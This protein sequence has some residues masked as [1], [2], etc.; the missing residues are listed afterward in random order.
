MEQFGVRS[1]I[2]IV[3]LLGTHRK[4]NRIGNWHVCE[5]HSSSRCRGRPDSNI[6]QKGTQMVG[7]RGDTWCSLPFRKDS[8]LQDAP[9]DDA[10][11]ILRRVA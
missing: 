3:D 10:S 9:C 11:L 1:L 6:T 7:R 4:S 8:A 5:T 2:L